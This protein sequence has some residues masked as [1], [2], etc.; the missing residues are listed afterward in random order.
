MITD[1]ISDM[2]ARIKNALAVRKSEVSIPFSNVKFGIAKILE[3]EAF[4]ER[5]Q[6]V[7]E[8]KFPLIR[9]TLRY[10]N[11]KEPSI[12]RICRVSRPGCRVYAKSTELPR[13]LA[14]IGIAIVSTPNGL[15]TNKEARARHLGGEVICEIS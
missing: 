1:P 12:H 2:L 13:V 6:R 10:Q 14:D 9:I 4:V 5:V 3:K 15:M 11:G 8:Q 7:D